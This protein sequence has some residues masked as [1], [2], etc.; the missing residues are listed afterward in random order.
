MGPSEGRGVVNFYGDN[1]RADY[2]LAELGCKIGTARGRAEYV[3]ERQVKCIVEN[4][5]LP[6]EDQDSLPATV[7][8]N[9]YSYTT[10]TEKTMFRPYGIR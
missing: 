7:S 2:P 8:L 1:F 5:P 10:P 9:S 3:S 4:M 6:A